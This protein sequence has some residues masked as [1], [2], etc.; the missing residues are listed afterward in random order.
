[1]ASDP[2][3]RFRSRTS[4][5]GTSSRCSRSPRR[6]TRRPHG[7]ASTSRRS[8]GSASATASSDGRSRSRKAKQH[9]VTLHAHREH[10]AREEATEVAGDLYRHG[11]ARRRRE[12]RAFKLQRQ[13]I[14]DRTGPTDPTNVERRAL[15]GG[16]S[17]EDLLPARRQSS[18]KRGGRERGVAA[19]DAHE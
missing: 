5:G 13:E 7:S 10:V 19:R 3:A 16:A 4:S 9:S 15:I 12:R 18:R 2:R 11:S 8:G 17:G 1:R 6:S 14:R